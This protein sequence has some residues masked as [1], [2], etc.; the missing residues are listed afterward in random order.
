MN[1]QTRPLAIAAALALAA[2]QPALAATR[3][4]D[5]GLA[6]GMLAENWMYVLGGSAG[7]VLLFGGIG[8]GVGK[9]VG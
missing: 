9:A 5:A 2:S 7:A 3:F 1:I 6:S 4:V 8:L